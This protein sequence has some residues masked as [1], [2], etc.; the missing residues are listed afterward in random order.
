M[1]GTC[2]GS[3]DRSRRCSVCIFRLCL[4]VKEPRALRGRSSLFSWMFQVFFLLSSKMWN[5]FDD[6]W[7]SS[8][9]GKNVKESSAWGMSKAHH[10]G[11]KSRRMHLNGWI[12]K[13]IKVMKHCERWES[14]R[15]KGT[16]FGIIG[17]E[18][19]VIGSLA[20]LGWIASKV[21]QQRTFG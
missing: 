10:N 17:L 4:R 13:L 6:A 7:K 11:T 19:S 14:K 3:G 9:R 5:W 12:C 21:S 18:L 8:R 16:F 15:E 1:F 2:F 20:E